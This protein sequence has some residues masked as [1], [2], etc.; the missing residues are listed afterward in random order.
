MIKNPIYKTVSKY[1]FIINKKLIKNKISY[2]NA[3]KFT[4]Q[5]DDDKYSSDLPKS[6]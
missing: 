2:K 3:G 6:Y 5:A 1:T 4:S